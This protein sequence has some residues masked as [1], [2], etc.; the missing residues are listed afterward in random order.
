MVASGWLS[1]PAVMT[2]SAKKVLD[3]ALAL[4]ED[5]RRRLLEALL[6]NV[7]PEDADTIELAWLNEVRSRAG[8]LEAGR[9]TARD[10][11]QA[12]SALDDRLRRIHSK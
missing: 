1:Y 4:P 10:G 6:D 9:T 12:L 3:D 2:A 5:D 8:R 11:D 7:P